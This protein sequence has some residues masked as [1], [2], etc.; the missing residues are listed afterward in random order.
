LFQTV[1]MPAKIIRYLCFLLILYFFIT[2]CPVSAGELKEQESVLINNP[3]YRFTLGS[4]NEDNVGTGR[5]GDVTFQYYIAGYDRFSFR[6]DNFTG[7]NPTNRYWANYGAIPLYGSQD[8]RISASPGIMLLTSSNRSQFFLGTNVKFDF[9]RINFDVEQRSYFTSGRSL[10]Y[11]FTNYNPFRNL[12]A[13]HIYWTYS[14]GMP[15]SYLGPKVNFNINQDA[16]IFA[17][18][19]FSLTRQAPAA[20]ML[21]LGGSVEF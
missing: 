10:H 8:V 20:R 1:K 4:W 11:T 21:Q 13:S 12:S 19:G 3:T 18:Y 14:D 7:G 6:W 17:M 2:L 5:R 9:P 15:R 16:N